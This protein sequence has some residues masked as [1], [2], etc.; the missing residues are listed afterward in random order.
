MV[1]SLTLNIPAA[2]ENFSLNFIVKK[3]MAKGTT[4]TIFHKQ[5]SDCGTAHQHQKQQHVVWAGP[6]SRSGHWEYPGNNKTRS[7]I[8]DPAEV[9]PALILRWNISQNKA[10]V[11]FSGLETENIKV[12]V[13][14]DDTVSICGHV[15]PQLCT[16]LH[17]YIY[18]LNI[19]MHT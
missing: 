2:F 9:L 4:R 11:T 6:R 15:Q 18:I 13:I 16:Y 17:I 1:S 12:K 3:Q 19:Y 14:S 5:Y 10:G 7:S 8:C